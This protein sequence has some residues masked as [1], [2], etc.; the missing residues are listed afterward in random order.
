MGASGECEGVSY[1]LVRGHNGVVNC[2]RGIGAGR[3][4]RGG[5]ADS[6]VNVELGL[7]WAW[8]WASIQ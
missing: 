7:A 3:L 6:L 1:S 5:R 2:D 4:F 8:A